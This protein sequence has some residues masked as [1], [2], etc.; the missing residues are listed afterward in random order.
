MIIP[1][2]AGVV[3][4]RQYTGNSDGAAPKKRSGMDAFIKEMI[5]AGQGAIWDNGSYGI[6][7]MR[8]SEALSVHA[9]GRAVDLSY[10]PSEKRKLA[11]RKDA[12]ALINKIVPVAN[13]LGIEMIIDYMPQP[14]GRAWRCDR[15]AW[16]KY[17]KPTVHGAPG[18][19]WFHIEITP[20]AADSAIFVKAAF[21]K[22]FGEIHPY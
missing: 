14:F 6:R 19:D 7:P 1:A 4:G 5:W 21:L 22:A 12:L 11:N 9:T 18:G 13:D 17:S 2:K 3:N 10:R 15:Q 20:Q 16:Q 8:G